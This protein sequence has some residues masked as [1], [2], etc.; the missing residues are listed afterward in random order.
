M[1]NEGIP[2]DQTG[3]TTASHGGDSTTDDYTHNQGG[4]RSSSAAE[5]TTSQTREFNDDEDDRVSS[6]SSLDP[7]TTDHHDRGNPDEV[8]GQDHISSVSGDNAPRTEDQEPA[9]GSSAPQDTEVILT[10]TSPAS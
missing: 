5:V 6:F 10:Q 9:R 1:G 8:G 4:Q 2:H 7:N 3:Q